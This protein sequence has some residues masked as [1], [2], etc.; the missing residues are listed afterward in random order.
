[1]DLD[2]AGNQ[3]V[4]FSRAWSVHNFRLSPC[5]SHRNHSPPP[6]P[7]SKM[8]P[9]DPSRCFF[10]PKKV[11]IP[12]PSEPDMSSVVCRLKEL[13]ERGQP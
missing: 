4:C 13:T 8:R 1:M 5:L 12:V 3:S 11:D 9:V 6:P 10:F 2:G 7:L